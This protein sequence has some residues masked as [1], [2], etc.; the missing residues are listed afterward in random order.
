MFVF[1]SNV[2]S[3]SIINH[4]GII[5]YRS[6]ACVQQQRNFGSE[7]VVFWNFFCEHM[8]LRYNWKWQSKFLN[9]KWLKIVTQN[10]LEKSDSKFSRQNFGLHLHR[11][12]RRNPKLSSYIKTES[13]RDEIG[14]VVHIASIN[15]SGLGQTLG[16]SQIGEI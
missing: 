5:N 6:G 16:W 8:D 3:F 14:S 4:W 9:S 1:G 13:K 15:V 7:I 2:R 11:K 12:S 10:V